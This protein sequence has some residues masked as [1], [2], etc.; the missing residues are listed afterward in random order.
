MKR[1]RREVRLEKL[2]AGV[3]VVLIPFHPCWDAVIYDPKN[4]QQ[5]VPSP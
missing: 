1:K 3:G 4:L 5:G 2:K